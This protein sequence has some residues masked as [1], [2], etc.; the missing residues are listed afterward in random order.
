[1]T[2]KSI[3]TTTTIPETT[4]KLIITKVTTTKPIIQTTTMPLTTKMTLTTTKF[5]TILNNKKTI[6]NRTSTKKQKI[7]ENNDLIA[8]KDMIISATALPTIT[9]LDNK[10]QSIVFYFLNCQKNYLKKFNQVAQTQNFK[11]T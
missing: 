6:K 9:I 3:T 8:L 4:T 10:L 11:I 5:S 2:T 7:I 1:M